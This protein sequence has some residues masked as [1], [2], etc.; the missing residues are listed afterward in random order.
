[1][2]GGGLTEF[3]E[4]LYVADGPV[5]PFLTMPYSTRMVVAPLRGNRLFVWSPVPLT[6]EIR[7]DVD[8]LGMVSYLV[9]PNSLH[10]LFLEEW[11]DTYPNA[12]LWGTAELCRK[13][14]AFNW[15]GMLTNT[16]PVGWRTE[17]EQTLFGGSILMDEA[18]F[19]HKQ[20][21]TVIF[22][23]LI[24]NFDPDWFGPVRRV[25]A[26]M[27]GIISPSSMA[28]LEYRLSFR[29]R[30][31]ARGALNTILGWHPERVVIAHGRN[32]SSRGE[33]FVRHSFRW[34][35]KDA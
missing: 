15:A 14:K 17:F 24:Q 26:Q 11:A 9:G 3:A 28:P 1:M 30:D 5:V 23:D 35:L 18:V 10:H 7:R 12:E 27:E 29:D 8:N 16:P 2:T 6:P 32:V 20:S 31:K 19:F 22:A 4:G 33:A 25:L 34:L 21:R 13:R